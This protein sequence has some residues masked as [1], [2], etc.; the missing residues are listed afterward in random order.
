MKNGTGSDAKTSH[1]FKFIHIY[2]GGEKQEETVQF[3][4]SNEKNKLIIIIAH[5]RCIKADIQRYLTLQGQ[6]ILNTLHQPAGRMRLASQEVLKLSGKCF[7]N[8]KQ[9][10]GIRT[11][12][13]KYQDYRTKTAP[14]LKKSP[15]P[16]PRGLAS[17]P[18]SPAPPGQKV[19]RMTQ[20]NTTLYNQTIQI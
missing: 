1:L 18:A 5:H 19:L 11:Q 14:I 2:F 13:H 10:F 3:I 6:S 8:I 16:G 12:L 9:C 15:A 20:H 4:L 7:Y 17:L